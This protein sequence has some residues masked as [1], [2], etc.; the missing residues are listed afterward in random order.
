M[1]CVYKEESFNTTFKMVLKI[2]GPE[3][4]KKK[5]GEGEAFQNE[6]R[7]NWENKKERKLR[8]KKNLLLPLKKL[9]EK[10]CSAL[11]PPALVW[12]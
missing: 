10:G 1:L 11:S 12:S 8:R 2:F 7:V 3:R 4:V 6:R 5:M 9:S